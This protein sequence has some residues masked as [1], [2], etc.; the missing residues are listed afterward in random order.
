MVVAALFGKVTVTPSNN[1]NLLD[2]VYWSSSYLD[3]PK[4]EPIP[5]ILNIKC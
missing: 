3:H 4:P 1:V 5:N 2:E